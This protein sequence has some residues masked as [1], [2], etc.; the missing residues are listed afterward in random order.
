MGAENIIRRR[1]QGRC[2]SKGNGCLW[3]PGCH[4]AGITKG[5]IEVPGDLKNLLSAPID[6]SD[7]TPACTSATTETSASTQSTSNRSRTVGP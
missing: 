3:R 6:Y 4:A 5:G 1:D 7:S 2:S